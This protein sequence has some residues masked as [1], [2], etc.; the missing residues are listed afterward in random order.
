M[1]N[2]EAVDAS[3]QRTPQCASD[4]LWF[5]LTGGARQAGIPSDTQTH[6]HT[7]P[8]YSHPLSLSLTHTRTHTHTLQ[9]WMNYIGAMYCPSPSLSL[10]P[11]ACVHTHK[12]K[13]A[14]TLSF[15]IAHLLR[16]LLPS[17]PC[18]P[19]AVPSLLISAFNQSFGFHVILALLLPG[20]AHL[21][22][23]NMPVAQSFEGVQF[24]ITLSRTSCRLGLKLLWLIVL[25]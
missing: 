12:H 22:G 5:N 10:W 3:R 9:W 1:V 17:L 2:Q 4:C 23:R 20:G 24:G 16:L 25:I 6:T 15:S 18:S 21:S 13:H 7:R 11:A 19:S 14:R 8:R